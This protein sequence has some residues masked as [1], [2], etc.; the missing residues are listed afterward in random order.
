LQAVLEAA[1]AG[2]AE[3]ITLYFG[4]DLTTMRANQIGDRLRQTWKRQ[5]IEVVEG[6]QPHY[7]LIVSLE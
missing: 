7:Q 4:A 1:D 5:E 3:L 6:R 2:S